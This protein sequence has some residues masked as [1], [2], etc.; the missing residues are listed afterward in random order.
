MHW[1]ERLG[2][3][4]SGS[5]VATADHVYV[6]DEEGS[7]HVIKVSDKYQLV[8]KHSLGETTRATPAVA[9]NRIYFRTDSRLIC[10]GNK[11]N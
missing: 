1:K 2:E 4:F 6:M 11:A 7:L 10:V 3:G 8:S 5:P 9:D